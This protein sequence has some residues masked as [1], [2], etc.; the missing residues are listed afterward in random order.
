MKL[1]RARPP[2]E[3][4][5]MRFI[6]IDYGTRRLGL[7]YGDELGVATPLPAQVDADADRRWAG[8]VAMVKVVMVPN[9]MRQGNSMTGIQEGRE[10][11]LA[12]KRPMTSLSS[13]LR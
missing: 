13:P 2:G 11:P 8:M 3:V 6:G 5:G 9:M 7:A 12:P 10:R 1:R 4:M